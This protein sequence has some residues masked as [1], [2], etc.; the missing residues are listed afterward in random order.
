MQPEDPFDAVH[1]AAAREVE[2]FA[3][4][5]ESGGRMDKGEARLHA[6]NA[7]LFVEFL[8]NTYPKMP[9]DATERDLW[10]FLFDYA[11]THGPFAGPV[12][13]LTPRSLA[14]F[15]EFVARLRRVHEIEP[16]RA[17]CAM[18]ALYLQRLES[19]ER[20][21]AR[22]LKGG[23]EDEALARDVD[24]WWSDLDRA[25]RQR[26]LVP[27]ASLAGGEETW[28]SEM[29]PL[30]AAV[31]D[32]LCLVLSRR[33]RELAS[34]GAAPGAIEAELLK[35]QRN[36]MTQKNRGLGAAPFDAV[37]KERAELERRFERGP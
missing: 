20:I 6:D 28:A 32:A 23:R 7:Y 14:L 19:Y 37:L 34:A 21:A 30:E 16:I 3:Q 33:A 5:L 11:I 25:M 8:A 29:G 31:F 4:A 24:S 26:G 17:A 18:E 9:E 15:V 22:A 12:T 1:L 10:V 35:A 13:R 36:F 27:D 2:A